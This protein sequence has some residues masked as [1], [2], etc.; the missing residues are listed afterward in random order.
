MANKLRGTL[1]LWL[2]ALAGL[3]PFALAVLLYYGPWE[4]DWLPRLPGSR[5]LVEPPI[6]LPQDWLGPAPDAA[7]GAYPWSLIYVRIT[8]CEQSCIE[9]LTR[10]R[11]VHLAVGRDIDRVQRVLLHAGEAPRLPNDGPILVR[12]LD[13]DR[14][15]A[16]VDALGAERLEE[17]RIFIAD[18]GGNL[19]AGYPPDVEQRELL[20][21]LQRLL[22]V[23]RTR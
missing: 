19:V 7:P 10:L 22:S 11:Q 2:V 18:P 1:A 12:T 15:P 8:P 3:G 23:S 5:E 13:G 14:G 4:L 21:D 9:H 6:P 17:G 20:R 16:L